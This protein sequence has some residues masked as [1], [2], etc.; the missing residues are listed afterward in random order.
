MSNS[1]SADS[2]QETL[3][4][5]LRPFGL[6][7]CIKNEILVLKTTSGMSCTYSARYFVPVLF[8]GIVEP[9]TID[10]RLVQLGSA[11][12]RING[13]VFPVTNCGLATGIDE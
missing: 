13:R 10:A 6:T 9:G 4:E 12:L 11:E 1:R 2:C 5:R 8:P 7:A 3:E